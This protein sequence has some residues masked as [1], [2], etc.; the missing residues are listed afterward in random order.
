MKKINQ[1]LLYDLEDTFDKKL[2]SQPNPS[3]FKVDV[4]L[5]LEQWRNPKSED[6]VMLMALIKKTYYHLR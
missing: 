2:R 5:E 1:Y 3:S 4:R 6:K